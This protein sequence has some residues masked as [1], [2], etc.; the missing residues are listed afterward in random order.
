[1]LDAMKLCNSPFAAGKNQWGQAR[2]IALI[3][4]FPEC[5][6]AEGMQPSLRN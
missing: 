5:W 2:L 3:Q 4:L 1:M 6:V